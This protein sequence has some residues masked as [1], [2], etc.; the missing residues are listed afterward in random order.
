[1]FSFN[2]ISDFVKNC[3]ALNFNLTGVLLLQA[4]YCALYHFGHKPLPHILLLSIILVTDGA[5]LTF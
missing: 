2:S 5:S 4:S 3:K 1:M